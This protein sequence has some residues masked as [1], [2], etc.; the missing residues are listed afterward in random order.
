MGSDVVV[1]LGP[2]TRDGDTF[3]GFNG[4]RPPGER[5]ALRRV[6]GRAFSLGEKVALDSLE[7][8]QVRQTCTVLGWQPAGCRGYL[9]GVN[10]HQI[11]LGCAHW[12]STLSSPQPALLG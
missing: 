2:A 3:L 6:P 12:E 10:E 5:Q 7:V 8:P 4:H 1:A 11:A 9:F